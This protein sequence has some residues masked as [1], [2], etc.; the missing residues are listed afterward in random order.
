MKTR[1]IAI[2]IAITAITGSY[3]LAAD[4]PNPWVLAIAAAGLPVS[5][6]IITAKKRAGHF[7]KNS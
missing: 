4:P 5:I 2:V 7:D 6:G 1:Y 3:W